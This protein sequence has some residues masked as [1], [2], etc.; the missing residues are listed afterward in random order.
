MHTKLWLEG[1]MG[2]SMFE[3]L[4]LSGPSGKKFSYCR[5]IHLAQDR[6]RSWD[7]VNMDMDL[8]VI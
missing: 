8:R 3:R 2:R 7:L 5:C 6:A 4:E 1:L